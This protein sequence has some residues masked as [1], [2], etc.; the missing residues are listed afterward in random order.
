MTTLFVLTVTGL[1][2]SALYFLVAAGL[3]LVFGLADVLN[4][5]HGLFLTLGAYVAWW[6]M[7]GLPG[8]F[9]TAL[10]LATAAGVAAAVGVEYVVVR[11]LYGR[12]VQQVLATVGLS[13]AGTAALVV[14]FG[15]DPR[16]VV[17]PDWTQRVIRVGSGALPV[18]RLLLIGAA[19]LV[20]V[21]LLLTL[22]YTRLGLTIR[23][24]VENREMV[25]ALGIDVHRAFA[26]VF[27]VAGGIAAFAG[28]LAG[29]YFRAVTPD[30]GNA[31]LIFAIIT[32]VIGGLGS[33]TGTAAAAMVVG[34]TQQYVNF[35]AAAGLGDICVLVV[36]AGILLLRPRGIAG[37]RL[38]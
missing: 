11:P 16:S 17:S 34:L 21:G 26:V 8:G 12:P 28:A 14:G 37:R 32:V 10:V 35:Y 33:I 6:V 20:L 3:S 38:A 25:S 7:T 15:P 23:A 2:I 31:L 29:T 13:L 19:V 18:N 27:A 22:R 36:L 24:G 30:Q 5:A 1:G 4:F 9:V